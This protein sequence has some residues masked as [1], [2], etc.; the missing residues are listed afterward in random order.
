MLFNSDKCEKNP[1]TVL[2]DSI[3]VLKDEKA[4]LS[5][6]NIKDMSVDDWA[7]NLKKI[8]EKKKKGN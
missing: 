1:L 7:S 3:R 5:S 4:R 2:N 8:I 6:A